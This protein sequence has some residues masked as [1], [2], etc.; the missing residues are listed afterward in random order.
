MP[1]VDQLFG[2]EVDC[3]V[4]GCEY[5]LDAAASMGNLVGNRWIAFLPDPSIWPN[6]GQTFAQVVHTDGVTVSVLFKRPKPAGP[7]DE[8]PRMGKQE[9]AV[10]PLAHLGADWLGCDPGKTNMATVAHEERYASGA[11][12]SVWQRSLSAGQYYRQSGITQH[13]KT[14]N[15]TP[16]MLDKLLEAARTNPQLRAKFNAVV[17]TFSG[18]SKAPDDPPSGDNPEDTP[19][20]GMEEGEMDEQRPRYIGGDEDYILELEAQQLQIQAENEALRQALSTITSQT[21]GLMRA[22]APIALAFCDD[23]ER[24]CERC[25]LDVASTLPAFLTG[26]ARNTW[27]PSIKESYAALYADAPDWPYLRTAFCEYTGD[28]L[29]DDCNIARTKLLDGAVKM[30]AGML[31]GQYITEFRNNLLFAGNDSMC[32]PL[33]AMVFTRGLSSALQPAVLKDLAH[34]KDPTLSQAMEAA[35]QAQRNVVMLSTTTPSKGAGTSGVHAVQ[36]SS[37][38]GGEAHPG[39]RGSKPPVSGGA[40]KRPRHDEL[41]SKKPL[42]PGQYCFKCNHPGH[43]TNH[44][45]P[46]RHFTAIEARRRSGYPNPPEGAKKS[47]QAKSKPPSES[48]ASE[49]D[50][51]PEPQP[52]PKA[53]RPRD[54]GMRRGVSRARIATNPDGY[55]A[56]ANDY[57][58]GTNSYRDGVNDYRDGANGYRAGANDYR[59]GAIG[60]RDGVNDYRD[61]AN[62]YRAGAAGYRAGANDYRDGA[63]GYRAGANRYRAVAN[64]YRAGANDYR[65]EANNYRAGANNYRAGGNGYRS[66]VSG[67]EVVYTPLSAK[68]AAKW[69]K[70]GGTGVVALVSYENL[71]DPPGVPPEQ[72]AQLKSLLMEFSD[73]FEPITGLPPARDSTPFLVN[74]GQSPITPVLHKLPRP[75]LSPSAESFAKK[76]EHEVKHAQECMRVAQDRQQRYANKR[77][78]DVTFSVGDSVLLSTKNLRNAPGRA[79]KFLPR[80]VGPFKVTGKLGEAAYRLELPPTMSRLH[81]VFHVSLLKKYTGSQ[82]FPPPPVMEWLEDAPH[83][84]VHSLLSHRQVRFKKRMEYLVKWTGYDDTYNTW[85]PEAMLAG[86]PQILSSGYAVTSKAWMAGIQHEHAVLSQVTN[87]TASLQRY[88]EYVAMTL[89]TWPAMWA[90]MSKP[91]WSNA[92]FRLYGGKQRTVAKFWAETVRGAMVRCNSAATGRPL[93]LAY[94]AAGFS[95]A[96]SMGSR[97]VPVKQMLREACRHFPGRVLMV[98]EFRTSRV[99]SAHTNVVAGHAEGFRCLRPVRSMATLSRIRGLMCSTSTGIRFYDRDVSAALNICRIAAGPGRPRELSSWLGRPAMPNPGRPG[100]EWVCVRDRGLLRKRQRRHQRQR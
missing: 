5:G 74:Y 30:T 39:R 55:R 80:Y 58:A 33:L 9:G 20:G 89:V 97:G 95:G 36:A 38:L 69:L 10:N 87:Y 79:R 60:Y 31:L 53:S 66:G 49:S 70:D 75:C 19:G 21:S 59:A 8:L 23:L 57:R 40:G 65:A 15:V 84:E 62:G 6:D 14:S 18:G 92:R 68:T 61:G 90:E 98:H 47:G 91:R 22:A 46:F 25:R 76:W 44:P 73:V 54:Q 99:S 78:R 42:L 83:Y 4:C 94:G 85:E 52:P 86:A 1:S 64:P 50:Q 11:V 88:R 43:L 56:G 82:G 41:W 77:R 51:E 26:A 17:E 13:A 71:Q 67:P 45:C 28:D 81:P 2:R 29:R 100:Q 72:A 32:Q 7:P 96:G 3:R 63:N 24:H 37:A 27:Y 35:K 93:A 34:F 16:D 12:E 48:G